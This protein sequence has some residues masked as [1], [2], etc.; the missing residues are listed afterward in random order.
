[1][2]QVL[3]QRLNECQIKLSDIETYIIKPSGIWCGFIYTSHLEDLGTAN[4][5]F[6]IY[7]ISDSKVESNKIIENTKFGLQQCFIND[8]LLDIEYWTL[9]TIESLLQKVN[10]LSSSIDVAELKLLHRLLLADSFGD[11][12]FCNK[13][14][15]QIANGKLNEHVKNF[16]KV[17]AASFIEDAVYMFDAGY[18]S[19]SSSCAYKALDNAIGLVNARNGKT[20]L[21]GKWISKIF[22]DDPTIEQ[23]LKDNY[24]RLQLYPQVEEKNIKSYLE[25]KIEFVQDLLAESSIF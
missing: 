11:T 20:N 18:F 1:M 17:Q 3:I 8:N 23:E 9:N 19:C 14:Q 22:L 24:I 2:K 21:K 12:A 13:I 7:V 25:E 15:T 5:D 4:S 16:Y 10:S 6:D